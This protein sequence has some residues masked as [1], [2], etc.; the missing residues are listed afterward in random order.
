MKKVT[1]QQQNYRLSPQLIRVLEDAA[2]ATGLSK[3]QVIETCLARYAMTL[4]QVC[5][6][7]RREIMKVV[8]AHLGQDA[9]KKR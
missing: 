7:A 8:A 9:R 1:K 6:Q 3:T 2:A 5:E 4:P